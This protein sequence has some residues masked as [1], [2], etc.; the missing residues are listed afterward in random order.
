M[1]GSVSG[2]VP[3]PDEEGGMHRRRTLISLAGVIGLL[4]TLF[5]SSAAPAVADDLSQ[6][7]RFLSPISPGGDFDAAPPATIADSTKYPAAVSVAALA[8]GKFVYWNGLENLETAKYPLPLNAAD[9][10][11][12]SRS[13]QLDVSAGTAAVQTPT[14]EDGGGGDMFCA[15]LRLTLDGGVI[16]AGGTIWKNDPVD[17]S[18]VT[19]PLDG[20]GGTAELFGN[21]ATRVFKSDSNGGTWTQADRMKYGRWYPAMVTMTDGRIFVAGGVGRLLYNNEGVNVRRT[22]TFNPYQT[23]GSYNSAAGKWSDNGVTAET[24]LPLFARLHVVHDGRVFYGANGQMWGPFGQSADQ[25]L[26]NFMKFYNPATNNWDDVG[27]PQGT[28][29]STPSRLGDWGA[30]S[31]AAEVMLP[32]TPDADGNYTETNILQAG[33]V[34]GTSPGTFVATNLTRKINISNI[35]RVSVTPVG[36]LA[37]RRWYSAGVIGASG[38]VFVLNGAD[39]DEVICG[40][41]ESAVRQAEMYDVETNQ[42]STLATA[43]RDRT[44]HNSAILM[45]DGRILVGGHSP[46]NTFYGPGA[47]ANDIHNNTGLTANNLKDSSFQIFEPPYLHR[48]PRPSIT[49]NVSGIL[50][51]GSERNFTTPDAATVQDAILVHM[52]S[53]THVVDG[54]ARAIVLPITSRQSG[55]VKVKIPTERGVATPGYYYLFLRRTNAGFSDPTVSN[56]ITVRVGNDAVFGEV[57]AAPAALATGAISAGAAAQAAPISLP[58]PAVAAAQPAS[59]SAAASRSERRSAGGASAIAAAALVSGFGVMLR[60]RRIARSA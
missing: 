48:G 43:T 13:R 40:G 27:T 42:W 8:N 58:A 4:G 20:P 47:G 5:L 60:R 10:S 25:A 50:E 18:A 57:A 9:V 49:S 3:G 59:V 15:D 38:D 7:G 33:G 12:N 46:I 31:G 11:K 14:P 44:Y 34:L 2:Q 19:Y 28:N 17:V 26:W 16:V 56:G 53:Q 55:S 6:T 35:G 45:Q 30:V 1:A 54:D 39:K 29:P 22:E 41:C 21:N 37:N 51:W 52:P 24:T 32:F 23:D 36:T